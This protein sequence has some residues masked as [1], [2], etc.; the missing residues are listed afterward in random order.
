MTTRILCGLLFFV[1]LDVP[2]WA[3]AADP[4]AAEPAAA[5]G[6]APAPLLAFDGP[7]PPPL[8]ATMARDAEGRTTVRAIRLDVPLRVDGLLDE[9]LYTSVR[10]ASDFVQAEPR[11][12]EPGTEK[13]EIWISFDDRN[14]YVSVRAE[15][16]QP[17]R[18]VLNE[19][20][21]DSNQIFQNEGIGIAFDT[22]YDRRNSVNF[23]ISPIGGRADGQVTNEGNYSGDWNPIWSFAVRRSATGWTGEMAIPFKS[24]R[25][26]PGRAQIWGVQVR[27]N[28]RWKNEYSFLTRVPAGLAANGI[29]RVSRFAALVGLEAPPGPRALD[30]KPYVTSGISTDL[31]ATPGVRN[32]VAKDAGLDLKWGVTGGLTADLTYNTDFAQVEADEQQVNLTRFSL[33]FPEKRDFFIENQGIFTFAGV[34]GTQGD[35]PIL[36]YS[37]RIGLEQGRGVP[38][39]AGGRLTGRVGRYS[40]GLLDIQTDEVANLGI[41]STNFAVARVRRDVLRRS[42]IGALVTRRSQ[43]SG[44]STGLGAGGTGAG[45]TY[46]LDGNFSFFTNLTIS[47]YWARTQTPGLHGDDTSYRG[48][49][50]YN[51]DRYG[52]QGEHL[53]VGANVNPQV[54]FLRRTDFVKERVQARFS[55]RPRNS[56]VVRKYIYQASGEYW[57]NHAGV[58][59]LR[60]I[61]GEF[62]IDFQSSDA[63]DVSYNDTFERIPAPFRIA[64]GVTIPAGGYDFRTLRGSFTLGQQRTA[65]GTVFVEGGRFYDGDRIA[66]GYSGARVKLN[67]RLAI[68]PGL[69]VNVVTL[70]FGEFTTKLVSSRVTYTMTSWMFVSGL[71]QYNSSNSSFNTN[72]R[73]RWEYLP[74][75]E[76]FV[77]YNEGRTTLQHGFPDLQTRSLVLKVNRLIRF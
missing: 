49:F 57:E 19:M 23:S 18:M 12:G 26:Q 16:S 36:F 32:E 42:S 29:F 73:F 58:R 48:Q 22:F 60:E 30:I 75:S 40:V 46:G 7:P 63:L 43:T 13:T 14:V 62:G 24:L 64:R 2:A 54:G 68:E 35:S 53:V 55:P 74:G 65:S 59:E 28:N 72:L 70:P 15:E 44:P 61:L 77:V 9:A 38:I 34:S 10:P 6:P 56:R 67:P 39:E 41:P 17:E 1:C 27:R 11:S 45:E 5:A 3:Q 51:G 66:F 33:F 71:V 4:P 8:P 76:L 37:R 50:N 25:Y 69:Q 20:R 47:T 31:T 52:L 21:R